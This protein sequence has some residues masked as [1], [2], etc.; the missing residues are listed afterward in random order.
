[1]IYERLLRVL[2]FFLLASASLQDLPASAQ[3]RGTSGLAPVS[4]GI[5]NTERQAML[6]HKS[7]YIVSR[8]KLKNSVESLRK[9]SS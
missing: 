4:A 2:A 8:E 7:L 5:G 6:E 9:N 3:V 1:M